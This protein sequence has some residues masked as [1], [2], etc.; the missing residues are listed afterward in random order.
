MK[1]WNEKIKNKQKTTNNIN[2]DLQ[3]NSSFVLFSAHS[4][5]PWKLCIPVSLHSIW[6]FLPVP[7]MADS[8]R[9]ADSGWSL[10]ASDMLVRKWMRWKLNVT[11]MMNSGCLEGRGD[12][13]MQSH[14]CWHHW[15][16]S[17]HSQA[18]CSST[19]LTNLTKPWLEALW[20]INHDSS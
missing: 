3:M 13:T 5:S 1:A 20:E 2:F 10:I 8:D 6:V 7:E 4:C 14:D 19:L 18:L 17:P 11:F 15:E 9:T 16:S 12:I